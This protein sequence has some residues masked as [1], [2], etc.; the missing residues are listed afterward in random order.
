M[1]SFSDR[2]NFHIEIFGLKNKDKRVFSSFSLN[3]FF[4]F[5]NRIPNKK[6]KCF[7]FLS[8][9]VFKA[10]LTWITTMKWIWSKILW[11][12][13]HWSEREREKWQKKEEKDTDRDRFESNR[14]KMANR[15]FEI[16]SLELKRKKRRWKIKKKKQ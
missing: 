12:R 13:S 10:L 15:K 11:D 3:S 7:L 5:S 2:F 1:R 14:L 16:Q 8:S 4:W 9:F 6:Q